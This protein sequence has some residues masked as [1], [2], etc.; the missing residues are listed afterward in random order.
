MDCSAV[1]VERSPRRTRQQARV[2]IAGNGPGHAAI[3]AAAAWDGP[4]VA[5]FG[6]LE[7]VAAT[8]GSRDRRWVTMD[9]VR[10]IVIL[11]STGSVGTQALDVVARNPDRFRIVALAAGGARP[12]LLAEQA[13]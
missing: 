7:R 11:G 4:L 13:I 8:R 12:E 3:R 1:E 6:A 9:G 5:I 2:V 10:D